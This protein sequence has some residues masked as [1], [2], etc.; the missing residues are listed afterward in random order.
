MNSKLFF[1]A[2]GLLGCEVPFK[3]PPPEP[4]PWA[5][6][7]SYPSASVVFEAPKAPFFADKTVLFECARAADCD[8]SVCMGACEEWRCELG[9]C[10]IADRAGRPCLRGVGGSEVGQCH[11]AECWPICASGEPCAGCVCPADSVCYEYCEG[12]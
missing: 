7:A 9:A 8:S 1:L 11:G 4:T 3:P 5:L 10:V 12:P 2:F 6:H